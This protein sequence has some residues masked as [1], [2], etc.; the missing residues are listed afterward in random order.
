MTTK[1]EILIEFCKQQKEVSKKS[2]PL[3]GVAELEEILAKEL[4]ITKSKEELLVKL[5]AELS[6]ILT[7]VSESSIEKKDVVIP[8]ETQLLEQIKEN[9]DILKY[10]D[11]ANDVTFMLKAIWK[12]PISIK[13]SGLVNDVTFMLKAIPGNPIVFMFASDE[14]KKNKEVVLAAVKY[15]DAM[16][17][18][19]TNDRQASQ[20]EQYEN[21]LNIYNSFLDL[22]QDSQ[23]GS[24]GFSKKN[25]QTSLQKNV[26]IILS[27]IAQ[28]IICSGGFLQL[29]DLPFRADKEVV[30]EAVKACG[31]SL[32]YASPELQADKEVVLKAVRTDPFALAHASPEL[33][34]DK[35]LVLEAVK[36]ERSALE[37]ASPELLADKEVV[38]TA[39]N[40]DS[41]EYSPIIS[42]VSPELRADPDVILAAVKNDY[43]NLQ[44]AD[45][46]LN[47]DPHFLLELLKVAKLK[48]EAISEY[49]DP[50]LMEKIYLAKREEVM[51]E[52]QKDPYYF[53]SVDRQ[54]ADTLREDKVFILEVMKL[55][56]LALKCFADPFKLYD[57]RTKVWSA[58]K[59]VV[60][61]AVKQNRDAFRY[62]SNE[63]KNDPD[64]ILAAQQ[65][66]VSVQPIQAQQ[67][68][69]KLVQLI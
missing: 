31:Y 24:Q 19:D 42:Y 21:L 23:Y 61:V 36:I 8:D 35:E 54:F 47:E 58:D 66:P 29:V 43:K 62:A 27:E 52:M 22:C 17:G 39:L 56:G 32:Q 4:K 20:D 9:P 68:A 46:S 64:V 38:M 16:R 40:T 5:M 63:L 14:L 44:Y 3:L 13:Y 15:Y 30:L 59:E 57:A 51:V 12:N 34:A 33:R 26:K 69:P 53:Y 41:L 55:N 1:L 2:Q 11:L 45:K 18:S 7:S 60:L 37:Y 49:V 48:P 28:E 6:A 25:S 10:S 50:T 65:V 67:Q